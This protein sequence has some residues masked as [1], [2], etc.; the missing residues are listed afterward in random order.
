MAEDTG[1]SASVL[2]TLRREQEAFEWT[3]AQWRLRVFAAFVLLSG[4]VWIVVELDPRFPAGMKAYNLIPVFYYS[5]ASIYALLVRRAVRRAPL[6]RAAVVSTVVLDCL[7]AIGIMLVFWIVPLPVPGGTEIAP[8]VT[9]DMM[10]WLWAS[11]TVA[12]SLLLICAFN[13]LRIDATLD[14][15]AAGTSLALFLIATWPVP[16]LAQ[17]IALSG[18]FVF[19]G[20][21]FATGATRT[22][23]LLDRFAREQLLRRY[24]APAAVDRVL[25]DPDAGL[26]PGGRSVVVT[27]VATDLRG[28]TALSEKLSPERTIEELNAYHRTMLREIERHGGMLDKF[29][30]DGA[31]VVFGLPLSGAENTKDDG[32]EAAVRCAKAMLG[33]LVAHNAERAALDRPPLAMGIGVHTGAVVSGNLGAGGRIEFT[34]IGDAVNTASRIEGLTKE[35][36]APLL[37]SA[38]TRARLDPKSFPEL[39]E[40]GPMAIRGKTDKLSLF[41]LHA[42]A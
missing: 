29:I 33:A 23:R 18:M 12:P 24:L 1:G 36:G 34:V 20:G 8:G 22:R 15:V 16:A 17:K 31:L 42:V 14:V 40:I 5:G 11:F 4:V 28:F 26:A 39:L 25:A 3:L 41:A 10:S 9:I 32:A 37:V 19:A 6:V 7:A 27:L 21:I 38:D 30:G 35:I 13:A 2:A